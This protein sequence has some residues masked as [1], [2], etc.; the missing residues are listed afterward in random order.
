MHRQGRYASQSDL[1]SIADSYISQRSFDATNQQIGDSTE[2]R[3]DDLPAL[4]EGHE[5]EQQDT[6]DTDNSLGTATSSR[7]KS[8]PVRSACNQ[9]QRRKTKCSGERPT[10]QFCH[11][12]GL[13]CSW[14][15]GYGITRAE[16]LRQKL[17]VADT[18]T[19][20]IGRWCTICVATL[21]ISRP[22]CW[23]SS[24]S[25]LQSKTW[26]R[27]FALGQRLLTIL[28]ALKQITRVLKGEHE[29]MSC[30]L[31]TID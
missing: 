29:F 31:K 7:K 2:A 14:Q 27:A 17:V 10:C 6:A 18:H 28:S 21:M 12:R 30:S 15:I 22:Y 24:V 4:D 13:T 11:D 20:D 23:R 1:S 25:V 19:E 5:S 3:N 16:D 9:C 8:K 26:Q